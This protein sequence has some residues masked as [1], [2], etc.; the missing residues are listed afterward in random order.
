MDIGTVDD[1]DGGKALYSLAVDTCNA[2]AWGGAKR[3]L[4]RT[5]AD[6]VL[7]QEHHLPSSRVAE[8]SAWALRRGWHSMFLP[9]AQG[10]GDGWRGGVAIL[11]RPHIGLSM[12]LV[13]PAEVVP[14]RVIAASIEPPGFRRCTVVSAYLED[15]GGMGTANLG[16]LQTIGRCVGMQGDH[17][18][19]IMGGDWQVAPE[20]M[21]ATG[22]ATQAGMTMVASGHARGTYRAARSSSELDYFL[23]TND[24]ALGMDSV[25]T[26]EGAGVR[27]HVPVRL[28]FRPRMASTRALHLRCPPPLPTSRMI[29]PLRQHPDWARARERAKALAKRAADPEDACGDDFAVEFARQYAEWADLAERELVEVTGAH[30]SAN[31]NAWDCEAEPLS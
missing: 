21:A 26:V 19:C 16:H 28:T 18:P 8:A 22:F 23:L 1:G 6:I 20:M 5:H 17:V 24:L 7:L 13:G 10:T 29:G 14:A 27:P 15:G 30:V 3:F 12:P 9:A 31:P 2:T 4:R 11:A 25:Q